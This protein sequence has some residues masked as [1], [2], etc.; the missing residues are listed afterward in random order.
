MNIYI[1]KLVCNFL[2]Y[3]CFNKIFILCKETNDKLNNE[4]YYRIIFKNNDKDLYQISKI[5]N[6]TSTYS[7][8]E[9]L[10]SRKNVIKR[11]DLLKDF[12]SKTQY[13]EKSSYDIKIIK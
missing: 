11:D 1:I 9:L 10:K 4:K 6:L 2:S 5:L 8:K 7:V 13:C 12:Y 3:E